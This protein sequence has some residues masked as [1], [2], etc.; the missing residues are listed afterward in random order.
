MVL[1]GAGID[2]RLSDPYLDPPDTDESVYSEKTIRLP[3]SFWCYRPTADTPDVNP[4]PALSNGFVTFGCLNN[5]CKVT[6]PALDLWASVLQSVADARMVIRCPIGSPRRQV[7]R[8]FEE[9]GINPDRIDFVNLLHLPEY[10]RRYQ[11]MDIAFDPI[12]YTG[13]STSLDAFWMGVP[14]VTLAG[15]TV[16]SRGGVSIASNLGLVE[17]I[18]KTGRGYVEIAAGLAGDLSGLAKLRATLRER[19]RG[20]PLMDERRFTLD[21][22]RAYQEMWRTWCEK[23]GER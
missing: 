18:A 12:P 7:L 16:A 15:E 13:H 23:K 4:L 21:I 20:S 5:F 22:E 1:F 8:R 6:A 14:V 3:H 2:Y 19:M 9:R 10:L 11:Q 17:L